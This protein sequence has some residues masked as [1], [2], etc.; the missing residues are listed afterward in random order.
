MLGETQTD[1]PYLKT[2]LQGCKER[3]LDFDYYSADKETILRAKTYAVTHPTYFDMQRVRYVSQSAL[4]LARWLQSIWTLDTFERQIRRHSSIMT[5]SD[6]SGSNCGHRMDSIT[7]VTTTTNHSYRSSMDQ[8]N[9]NESGTMTKTVSV[10]TTDPISMPESGSITK[11]VSTVT[12]DPIA[13]IADS[14]TTK[15]RKVD[16]SSRLSQVSQD[17]TG[18]AGVE[19]TSSETHVSTCEITRRVYAPKKIHGAAW[20]QD[21][22]FQNQLTSFGDIDWHQLSLEDKQFD[23]AHLFAEYEDEI[24]ESMGKVDWEMLP[25]S[26]KVKKFVSCIKVTKNNDTAPSECS[27][28]EGNNSIS[29][30]TS[31]VEGSLDNLRPANEKFLVVGQEPDNSNNS[32]EFGASADMVDWSEFDK[33]IDFYDSEME[34]QSKSQTDQLFEVNIFRVHWPKVKV[35]LQWEIL[36]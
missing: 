22:Y 30:H 27:T 10:A 15:S 21:L 33:Q 35:V 6:P 23:K 36:T 31:M 29:E 19:S 32:Q 9:S 16:R 17:S 14:D 8:R 5:S 13:S 2:F 28:I 26:P 3:L 34:E 7:T 1:W 18:S 24:R 4:L 20:I 25:D 12:T 11:T